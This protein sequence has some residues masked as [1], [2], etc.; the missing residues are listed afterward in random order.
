[1]QSGELRELTRQPRRGAQDFL[2][3]LDVS[4]GDAVLDRR[5]AFASLD[6]QPGQLDLADVLQQAKMAQEHDVLARHLE[7]AA[8][9]GQ[10]DGAVESVRPGVVVFVLE[11]TEEEHRVGIA[12]YAFAD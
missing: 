8:K 3:I 11:S 2:G 12:Q 7:E 4:L 1:M 9:G 10:V 6:E 5:E